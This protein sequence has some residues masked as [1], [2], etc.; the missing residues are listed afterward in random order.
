[1]NRKYASWRITG[2]LPW[3]ASFMIVG[4]TL[5]EVAAFFYDNSGLWISSRVFLY[6]AL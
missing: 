5:R 6:V 1:M 2:A 4:F 3:S